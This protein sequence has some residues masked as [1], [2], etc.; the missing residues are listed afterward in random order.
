ML[1]GRLVG[2]LEQRKDVLGDVS[3]HFLCLDRGH[4]LGREDFVVALRVEVDDYAVCSFLWWS[5]KE[6]GSWTQ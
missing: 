2:H 4:D 6:E 5:R 3:P 1:R